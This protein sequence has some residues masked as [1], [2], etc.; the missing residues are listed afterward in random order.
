MGS[1]IT[2]ADIISA[3]FLFILLCG[4]IFSFH[5]RDKSTFYF[6]CCI[7]AAF[8]GMVADA[9]CYITV[10]SD[11]SAMPMLVADFISFI[12]VGVLLI[13]FANYMFSVIETRASVPRWGI[14][15]VL[16][17]ALADMIMIVAGTINGKLIY[18]ENGEVMEGEWA[19]YPS[20]FAFLAI[21]YLYYAIICYRKALRTEQFLAIV[22]F[23]S[24]PIV[25]SWLTLINPD[26]DFTYPLIAV[27]FM[28][29]YVI[30]QEHAVAEDTIRKE[31]YEEDD[32]TDPVTGLKNRRAYDEAVKAEE[33]GRANGV[34]YCNVNHLN[35]IREKNGPAAVDKKV[36]EFYEILKDSFPGAEIYRTFENVFVAILY[37]ISEDTLQRKTGSFGE[38]MEQ[39]DNM[40]S[41]GYVYSD[42]DILFDMVR[43][44]EQN[45]GVG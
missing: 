38:A 34:V 1:I 18:T 19:D 13:L 41:F 29:I 33:R 36:L 2:Y 16:A 43:N 4:S 24:F 7:I 22:V 37:G 23:L 42:S 27:A 9:I 6:G 31:I 30:V 11:E 21:L 10:D 32:H 5:G 12:I 17:F 14:L 28:V 20:I 45:I 35:D 39:N 44:A 15:P 40:A 26:V 8:I 3:V 25:D